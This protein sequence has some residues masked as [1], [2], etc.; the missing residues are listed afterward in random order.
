[1]AKSLKT[2]EQFFYL[3][4]A[5]VHSLDLSLYQISIEVDGQEHYITDESGKMLRA[6]SILDLQRQCAKLKVK[7]WVLRQQSAYDEMVGS[8]STSGHNTLEVPL[9]DNRLY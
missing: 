7:K 5:I 9:G 8:V 2:L 4:K 6:F 1:M 3:D